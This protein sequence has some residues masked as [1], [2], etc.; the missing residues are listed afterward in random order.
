MTRHSGCQAQCVLD[1]Y[2]RLC[3]YADPDHDGPHSDADGSW[4]VDGREVTVDAHLHELS[5]G[6]WWA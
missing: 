5:F 4:L 6:E 2:D 1:G 3:I